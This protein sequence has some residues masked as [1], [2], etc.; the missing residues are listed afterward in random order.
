MSAFDLAEFLIALVFILAFF[1]LA[2]H[3]VLHKEALVH[4]ATMLG[5]AL[6]FIY[7]FLLSFNLPEVE[8]NIRFREVLNRPGVVVFV[9][10]ISLILLNGRLK[11]F[12]NRFTR[13]IRLSKLSAPALHSDIAHDKT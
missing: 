7:Y 2:Q 13:H 12:V 8:T 6:C 3:A 4:G 1:S 9:L 5:A 11:D 10:G